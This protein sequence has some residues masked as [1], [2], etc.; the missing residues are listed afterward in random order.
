MNDE[1][2]VTARL[3][4][5]EPADDWSPQPAAAWA[6]LEQ[7]PRRRSLW[8]AL[9]AAA[10][11]I[12]IAIP[13]PARCSI[14]SAGCPRFLAAATIAHNNT[15]DYKATGS[16]TAPITLE[17]YYDYECPY[18]ASFYNSVYPQLVAGF[19][20][21]GKV[22]VVHR[23]FPLP[24][25]PYS[26]LAARYANA[27]GETGHYSEA[28]AQLFKTQGQWAAN[29][30]ITAA[31]AQVLSP[32]EMEKIRSHLADPALDKTVAADLA[33]VAANHIDQTPGLVLVY[34]GKRQVMTAPES[35]DLL[36]RYLNEL[37]S[38]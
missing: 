21:T 3:H 4:A 2:F 12:L 17:I 18:C 30:N 1:E 7:R 26:K 36:R 20:D 19:V 25:H 31:L 6:R 22:R 32:A 23:D 34:K 14:A 11:L 29:G 13:T 10:A 5:L 15:G 38:H 35:Y 16:P 37:L 28:V 33:A 27:A 9:S 8:A 24:Q